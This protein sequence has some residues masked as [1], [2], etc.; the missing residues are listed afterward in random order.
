MLVRT[1]SLKSVVNWKFQLTS[2]LEGIRQLT[3][4]TPILHTSPPWHHLLVEH[5]HSASGLLLYLVSLSSQSWTLLGK[6]ETD[7]LSD[8]DWDWTIMTEI[9]IQW[10]YM[11]NNNFSGEACAV[12]LCRQWVFLEWECLINKSCDNVWC[13]VFKYFLLP[14]FSSLVTCGGELITT[15]I[16]LPAQL[17]YIIIASTWLR[18]RALS[19]CQSVSTL[20]KF[21]H[22]QF[23]WLIRLQSPDHDQQWPD[24]S[25]DAWSVIRSVEGTTLISEYIIIRAALWPDTEV[26]SLIQLHSSLPPCIVTRLLLHLPRYVTR[27]K[28]KPGVRWGWCSYLCILN[29]LQHWSRNKTCC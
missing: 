22:L 4:Q 9:W 19:A 1:Q 26:L 14:V 28:K 7:K 23:T 24:Y 2:G 29:N 12:E 11:L 3:G 16:I 15:T 20:L 5:E 18:L 17:R 13:I 27:L 8:S 21:N 10:F 6:N 25:V